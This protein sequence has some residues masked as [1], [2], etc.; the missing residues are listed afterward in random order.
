M[1]K[2]NFNAMQA[3]QECVDWIKTLSKSENFTRMVIGISGGKDST[4]A[5]ALCC[6]ALGAE[7]V[8]GL[9]MPNGIQK[10]FDDSLRVCKALGISYDTINIRPMYDAFLLQ[11]ALCT[12]GTSNRHVKSRVYD[13]TL[14]DELVEKQPEKIEITEDAK[15]N[16]APRIRAV[17]L[18]LWGQSHHARVCGT[19][20]LSEITVGYYTKDG[21]NRCDFQVLSNFTTLEV[22]EIGKTYEN[23]P[24][25]LIEK[26]PA[27]GLS[28]LTDEEK[29]GVSY[30]D[31]HKYIRNLDIDSDTWRKINQ[32]ERNN[33]HKRN[34]PCFM[35]SA[36]TLYTEEY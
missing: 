29:L 10:D 35:A 3:R 13:C 15:I 27:D 23:I 8:H 33:L 4:I 16:L 20:N 12:L 24:I 26:V 21:D 1:R 34:I 22:V 30:T 9:L 28:E 2:Y 18:R 5:A 32:M 36:S 6:E 11:Y 17:T 25:D 19:S 7:N 31:I 14:L